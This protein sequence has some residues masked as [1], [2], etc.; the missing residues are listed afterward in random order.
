MRGLDDLER[1]ADEAR[2]QVREARE[3]LAS[4]RTARGGGRARDA[5]DAERQLQSLRGAVTE[6]AR[7]LRKRL[8]GQDP[9]ATRGLRI[10]ALSAS[11]TVAGIVGAALVGRGALTRRSDRRSLQ[12]QASALA[13][14]L[15]AQA[16]TGVAGS[17][18][19]PP[20]PRRRGRRGVMLLALAGAV[21]AGAMIAQQRRIAPVDPDDLWLPVEPSGPA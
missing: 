20:T 9:A 21:T 1:A 5:K 7:L 11:G 15:A 2:S 12:R 16:L 18:P 10:A 4:S 6:D 13:R 19:A 14:A 8:S 17:E 3:A